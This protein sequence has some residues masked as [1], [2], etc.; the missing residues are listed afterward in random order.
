MLPWCGFQGWPVPVLESSF[1]VLALLWLA[2][3]SVHFE[4]NVWPQ[5]SLNIFGFIFLFRL[6]GVHVLLYVC[7]IISMTLH[8][9]RYFTMPWWLASRRIRHIWTHPHNV[10][11]TIVVEVWRLSCVNLYELSPP[12]LT[13]VSQLTQL[14]MVLVLDEDPCCPWAS[15]RDAP[16]PFLE[17]T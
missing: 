1:L 2:P 15:L 12:I 7:H 5:F 6:S 9:Q 8:S 10:H 14:W 3:T 11:T 4:S 13:R 16:C 17:R